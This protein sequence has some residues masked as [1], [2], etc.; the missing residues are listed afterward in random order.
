MSEQWLFQLGRERRLALAEL[1]AVLGPRRE[2]VQ[3]SLRTVILPTPLV[4]TPDTLQERLG[5]VIK[6]GRVLA[7]LPSDTSRAELRNWLT[8]DLIKR[9]I[10]DFGISLIDGRW[11]QVDRDQLGLSVKRSLKEHGGVG[12][13]V[14]GQ[15]LELPS[16]LVRDQLLG[17]GREY[18]IAWT[19]TTITLA[20][21][22]TVQ[23]WKSWSR[24]DYDRPARDTKRGMLPPKLARMMLNLG[25]FNREANILDPFC[26]V[27][28]V[29]Q[30][31][32]LLGF[33]H[34][35]G[36]DQDG[37]AIEDTK[38]NLDWLRRERSTLAF[39]LRLYHTSL[40]GLDRSL[41]RHVKPIIGITT[42]ADLGP[43]D[44]SSRPAMI[45]R[46]LF[47]KLG[48]LYASWLRHLFDLLERGE[49]AVL[50]YPLLREP[51]TSLPLLD[52]VEKIGWRVIPAFPTGWQEHPATE[53][54]KTPVLTYAREDQ[55]IA[56][57]IIQLVKP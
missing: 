33:T 48:P 50:A 26:G 49:R 56:R 11:K 36:S 54:Q 38:T 25:Q 20:E 2:P 35:I 10:R 24:R 16:V 46:E 23:P 18:L 55:L 3:G 31:A 21:T 44:L 22:V 37:R 41:L 32:A 47:Q 43:I 1:S 52:V 30:E 14:A 28:T 45:R 42:E 13:F 57:Q 51:H 7:Q 53:Q 15:A 27:G 9:P 40:Q 4:W 6:I 39:D 29:L 8:A 5:G 34:L 12:R 19:G 17:R